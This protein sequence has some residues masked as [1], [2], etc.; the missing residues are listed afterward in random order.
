MHWAIRRAVL[1]TPAFSL[2]LGVI[3]P[4]IL[5]Y[6][7]DLLL[8][9]TRRADLEELVQVL[10]PELHINAAKCEYLLKFSPTARNPLPPPKEEA[11]DLV[12]HRFPRV[13]KLV[14]LGAVNDKSAHTRLPERTV[15]IRL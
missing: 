13:D 11:V 3:V 1:R 14:Y 8:L 9:S 10:L 5:A 6:E 4:V 7:D 12:E 2:E 15:G